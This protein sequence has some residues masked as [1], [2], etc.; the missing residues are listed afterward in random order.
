MIRRGGARG[1]EEP[2]ARNPCLAGLGSSSPPPLFIPSDG[3][4]KWLSSGTG[5]KVRPA[6]DASSAAVLPTPGA[7]EGKFKRTIPESNAACVS[8]ETVRAPP[9]AEV[10]LNVRRCSGAP[11]AE[12]GKMRLGE[13]YR[14][15]GEAKNPVMAEGKRNHARA[16]RAWAG[17]RARLRFGLTPRRDGRRTGDENRSAPNWLPAKGAVGE[18]SKKKARHRAHKKPDACKTTQAARGTGC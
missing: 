16:D 14:A 2:G 10:R 9:A 5:K 8:R 11:L 18:R 6:W 13:S 4:P 7:C 17:L 15:R 1:T 12:D 3:R